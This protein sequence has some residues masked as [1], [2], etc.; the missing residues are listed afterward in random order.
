MNWKNLDSISAYKKLSE[1]KGHVN[2]QEVMSGENGAERVKKY[3]VPMAAGLTYY[4]AAKQ[5]DDEVLD[6]LQGSQCGI[7]RNAAGEAKITVK[8]TAISKTTIDTK[9]L[10]QFY[11]EAW[12]ATKK[13]SASTRF[14]IR[15]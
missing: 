8:N 11:P 1:L 9:K 4:Y 3:N 14:S 6:A 12:A 10:K 5:V 13:D 15:A 7:F 2:L